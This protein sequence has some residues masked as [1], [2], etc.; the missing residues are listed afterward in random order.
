M[1]LFC[2]RYLTVLK[3]IIFVA[4]MK[5]NVLG[6]KLHNFQWV[7]VIW[8]VVSVFM[9]GSTAILSGGKD[10]DDGA[11]AEGSNA[12]LGVSLVMLGAF[13]QSMQFVFEEKVLTV[14]FSVR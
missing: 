10:A 3:G 1:F 8:N 6:D 11:S 13:V 5:Q 14:S 12:L 2:I 4:I 9:V 7:G